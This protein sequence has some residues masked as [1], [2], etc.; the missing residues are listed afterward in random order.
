M[1][2]NFHDLGARRKACEDSHGREGNALPGMQQILCPHGQH[3][4]APE[5]PQERRKRQEHRSSDPRPKE[6]QSGKICKSVTYGEK[7]SHGANRHAVTGTRINRKTS[8]VQS[9]CIQLCLILFHDTCFAVRVRQPETP[10]PCISLQRLP[11]DHTLGRSIDG[12]RRTSAK[13]D[14]LFGNLQRFSFWKEII[15]G[16][17]AKGMDDRQV[18]FNYDPGG[19][20]VFL[21]WTGL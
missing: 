16:M 17:W 21:G 14:F 19:W 3:E 20:G 12:I 8:D 2:P 7:S 6:E 4:A 1:H 15:R 18:L 10:R 11:V 5:D 13:Q 9:K